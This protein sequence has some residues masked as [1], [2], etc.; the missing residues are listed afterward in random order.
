ME[1][2][3][4]RTVGKRQLGNLSTDRTTFKNYDWG[5]WTEL[6]WLR[7]GRGGRLL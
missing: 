2:V 7:T 5:T 4:G 3:R 6:I 1:E